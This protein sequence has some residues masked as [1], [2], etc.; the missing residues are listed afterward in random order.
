MNKIN[1]RDTFKSK[2]GTIA[3]LAGG[4]VGLGNIW[5]FPYIAG[6]NG[7]AAFILIY[8][9]VSLCVSIPALLSELALGRNQR[10][11]AFRVFRK[12]KDKHPWKNSGIL[13]IITG[14]LIFSFYCIIGGWALKYFELAIMN[15]FAGK[16]TAE[17]SESLNNFIQGGIEP[18]LYG[19]VITTFTTIIV[20]IGVV[21]GIERLN[22]ILMPLFIVLLLILVINSIFFLPNSKEGL[23]FILK[24][25]FSAVTWNT[26]FQAIGQSF[27]SLSLGMG[28]QVIYGSYISEKDNLV[29]TAVSVSLID[30]S[31][32]I[33]CGLAIFPAVF[34]FNIE[35]TAGP[36]LL[37]LTLPNIFTQMT[38][39]Y[40]FAILFFALVVFATVTSTV[41]LFEVS[42]SYVMEEFQIRRRTACLWVFFAL[43]LLSFLVAES[44]T[45][46]S[47]L[48]FFG[49]SLF[50]W[51]DQ[52][53]SN[54]MLPLGGIITVIFAGWIAPKTLLKDE[55]TNKSTLTTNTKY[56]SVIQIMIKYVSPFF[57]ILLFLELIGLL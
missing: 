50:D 45:K 39:G 56:F 3:V 51:F 42:V 49:K 18:Y 47:S 36:T 55:L 12:I 32:A 40:I 31:I 54:F 4:C 35:P 27:F 33:L 6:E 9:A 22:K 23:L 15:D 37:F 38:G 34:S 20:G 21:K 25:D 57:L 2:I 19:I 52:I 30:M 53:T 8:L 13:G 46:D 17:L 16:S 26:I 1:K 14:F 10:C 5:R 43:L 28:A 41:S 44:Q 24:P 7:G 29:K 48:V 11:N